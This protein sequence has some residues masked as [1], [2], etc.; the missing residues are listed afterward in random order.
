IVNISI[1]GAYIAGN[2]LQDGLIEAESYAWI[3]GNE[4]HRGSYLPSI[5]ARSSAA[6]ALILANRARCDYSGSSSD[7]CIHS[8]AAFS[9]I[10]GNLV[11]VNDTGDG[12]QSQYGI[13]A[14]SSGS[15]T[16]INNLVR[17][18]PSGATR[19]GAAID[20]S[21]AS[22]ARVAGNIITDWVST[23][24]PIS[25]EADLDEVTHN[26]CFNGSF[27]CPLGDGNVDGNPLF[28]DLIDYRLSA[29]SAAIDAGPPDDGLADLDRTRNDMG[30][31][32]GP[33]SIGQYDAQRA[34]GDFAPFVYPLFEVGSN[35]T[36][37]LLEVHALG[38]A[39]LR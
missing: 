32:G 2:T 35:L 11:L 33:W 14:T 3:V 5:I 22:Q 39:R 27:S 36:G 34:P 9:L 8:G 24:A 18:L 13:V 28:T 38:V 12:T 31:Y 21:P 4:V 20:A 1:D 10:A 7:G 15:A 23:S 16:I 6:K 17:G 19:A 29:G 37:G 30:I 26:L 25:F